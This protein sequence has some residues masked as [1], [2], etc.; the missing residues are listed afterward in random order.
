MLRP[1]WRIYCWAYGHDPF[2]NNPAQGKHARR[3]R[4]WR[5]ASLVTVPGV[6][7]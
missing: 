4:C 1:M 3:V 6:R 7:R 5:C 2:P